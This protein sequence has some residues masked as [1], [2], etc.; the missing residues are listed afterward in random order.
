MAL[1]IFLL[2]KINF[3]NYEFE[4]LKNISIK[5]LI[6]IHLMNQHLLPATRLQLLG[7]MFKLSKGKMALL[8]DTI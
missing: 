5:I 3:Y 7:S 2:N 4:M 1:S 6:I 8:Y